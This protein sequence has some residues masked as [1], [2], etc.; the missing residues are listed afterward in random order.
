MKEKNKKRYKDIESE[1]HLIQYLSNDK[2]NAIHLINQTDNY[3]FFKTEKI[4]MTETDKKVDTA[5]SKFR[6]ENI[7]NT[8]FNIKDDID[9]KILDS[10]IKTT[11][12]NNSSSFTIRKFSSTSF[13]FEDKLNYKLIIPHSKKITIHYHDFFSNNFMTY[14]NNSIFGG[15]E[16][17]IDNYTFQM[18]NL[19]NNFIVECCN[20]IDLKLFDKYCKVSLSAFGFVTGFVPMGSGYYFGYQD[21]N[22][23]QFLFTSDFYDTYDTQYSLLSTNAYEYYQNHDLNFSYDDETGFTKDENIENLENKLKPLE[24]DIFENLVTK[25]LKNEKFSE[26]I[27]SIF[28]INNLKSFSIYLKGGLYSITLEM[29]TSIVSNE[30][31]T[32][33]EENEEILKLENEKLKKDL[34]EELHKTAKIFYNDNN[35]TY[36]KSITDKKL[37]S[38]FNPFNAN[39]LSEPYDILNINLTEQDKKNIDK[40]NKF[41]HGSMPYKEKD[42][43]K[44]SKKLFYINLELNYLVNALVYKYIGYDGILKNLAKTFLDYTNIDELNNQEYY[45]SN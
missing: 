30:N 4:F 34:Q 15:I 1:I 6:F 35:L 25:M 26:V 45:R 32:K 36:D 2:D 42:Y 13:D 27:F 19:E 39:K 21:N 24:K 23:S 28:S 31:K 40:R 16:F 43:M 7:N 37:N 44:L 20:D 9:I 3:S 18:Y 5:S 17:R 11:D 8:I 29:I 10:Q 22:Y 12:G 14:I 41:L 38:I 33:K